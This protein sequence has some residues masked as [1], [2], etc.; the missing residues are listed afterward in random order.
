M[1]QNTYF[2]EIQVLFCNNWLFIC[3]TELLIDCD[4]IPH[5]IL[6]FINLNIQNFILKTLN[7]FQILFNMFYNNYSII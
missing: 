5:A 3:V 2:E 1:A 7:F 4:G 6:L